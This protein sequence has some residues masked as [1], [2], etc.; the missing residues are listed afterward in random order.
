VVIYGRHDVG[1]FLLEVGVIFWELSELDE[2]SAGG[3]TRFE[4][5]EPSKN[6]EVSR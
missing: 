6:D 1:K 2:Y 3:I 5:G 4:L